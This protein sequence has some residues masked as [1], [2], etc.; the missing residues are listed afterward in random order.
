LK[1]RQDLLSRLERAIVDGREGIA[2]AVDADFGGRSREETLISEVLVSVNAIRYVRP[3]IARWAKPRPVPVGLPFWPGRSWE[4]LQPLGVVGVLSPWNYPFQLAVV[5]VVSAIA[6]GNRVM[7][8]PS[9]S[10]ARTAD[11]LVDLLTRALGPEVAQVVTGDAAVAEEF[12]H[13]PLDHL[14]F[15]GSTQT[16]RQVMAAASRNLTPVTLELGGKCPAVVTADADLRLAARAIV[17]GKGLNAGQTCVA[18]DTVLLVGVRREA[19]E[20]ALREAATRHYAEGLPTG[21]ASGRQ[22]AR[23]RALAAGEEV[24]PL[25]AAGR[26]DRPARLAVASTRS[27]SRL[28]QEEIFGPLLAVETM[29]NLDDVESWLRTHPSPLAVY[30][31][32]RSRQT[33]R[34][35]LASS[36]AG[37]LVVNGTVLQAAID[38]LAFGGV[39]ASGFGRY[40]GRAGFETFSNRK[41]YVRASRFSLAR[42]LEP[43][44]TRRTGS[45]IARLLTYR[46]RAQN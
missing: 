23:L 10:T 3:R 30:L 13:L 38:G 39:G 1:T 27:G 24:T 34:R 35:L 33:E 8:K 25:T 15:T 2:A 9:E 44:Y 11:L 41:S 45:M 36:R 6:A 32:T 28:S 26:G 46:S 5:P 22:E 4:V 17:T 43:P 20:A 16:G 14:L 31:F 40:H 42:L 29:A 19:F 18:P 7:L 21:I 37:A 12:T